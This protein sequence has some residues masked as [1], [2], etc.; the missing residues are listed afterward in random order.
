MNE[1]ERDE[2]FIDCNR[3]TSYKRFIKDN[4]IGV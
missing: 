2:G 3:N 1:E 4:R